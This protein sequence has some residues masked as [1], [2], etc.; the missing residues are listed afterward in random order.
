MKISDLK[1]KIRQFFE[2]QFVLISKEQRKRIVSYGYIILTLFAIS[3]FGA[4][5]IAPTLSTISNLNKQYEDNK[6]I[7]TRLNT[8]LSAL[9]SLDKQYKDLE[10]DLPSIYQ[11]IPKSTKIPQLTRQIE[12]IAA[13]ENVTITKLTFGTIEVFPNQKNASIYSFAFNV[14]A[15]GGQVEINNF[16][17]SIIN[18]ERIIGIDRVITGQNEEKAYTVQITG[19]AYFSTK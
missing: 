13:S 16:I 4:F 19:R 1:T 18:F 11:A 14:T 12:N 15:Q 10:S 7:L 9:Q 6:L 17:S 8:K 3:F 5:A 2:S